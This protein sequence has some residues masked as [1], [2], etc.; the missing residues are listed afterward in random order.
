MSLSW[1]EIKDRALKFSREWADE[2]AEDA[3][4]KSL[5]DGFF[6]IFGVSR[7]RVATFEKR[8][9]KVDGKD[10]YIDLLWKGASLIEQDLCRP[11]A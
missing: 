3:E 1:N 10:G 2:V 4:A 8:V 7:R 9:K 6:D 5:W 11:V